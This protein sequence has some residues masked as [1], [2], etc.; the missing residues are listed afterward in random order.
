MEIPVDFRKESNTGS[1]GRANKKSRLTSRMRACLIGVVL[2]AS[3]SC[4]SYRKYEPSPTGVFYPNRCETI[5]GRKVHGIL[6]DRYI[7]FTLCQPVNI[8]E[9]GVATYGNSEY[10]DFNGNNGS[11]EVARLEFSNGGIYVWTSTLNQFGR[12]EYRVPE[13]FGMKISKLWSGFWSGLWN[14]LKL[15]VFLYI[16]CIILMVIGIFALFSK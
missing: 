5:R 12:I 14:T 13:T 2:A 6:N 10:G 4:V 7:V 11:H 3:T 15:G 9:F 1:I 16:L 8:S